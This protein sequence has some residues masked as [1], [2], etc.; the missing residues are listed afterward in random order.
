MKI[1]ELRAENFKK[2]RVVEIRPDGNLVP[3]TGKNGQ[4]KTSVL[5]AIWF[6]L[7]GK[8]ALPLK[9]VRKGTERMKV[10]L[11]TEE[12]TVT[13]TLTRE[14]SL[15]TIALEMKTGHKRDKTPQEFLDEV[16]GELTFDPLEFLQ[17]DAKAQVDMLRKTAKVDVDFDAVDAANQA[18]YNERTAI[19]REISALDGQ[20]KGIT[21][22]DGLPKQKIDEAAIMAKLN[23]AG[24]VNKKALEISQLKND[25]GTIASRVGLEKSNVQ[26]R[27]EEI[28]QQI[29]T[30]Q[31]ERAAKVEDKAE[32]DEKY[33]AAEKA[34]RDAPT[35]EPLDTAALTQELTNAQRTNRAINERTKWEELRTAREKKQKEADK[36]TRQMEARNEKKSAAIATAKIP[37]A[38][39]TFDE[40]QV[41]FNGMPL[42]SLGEGEQIRI[43]TQIGMAAN[44]KLRVLCIRHGEALD[45]DSLKILADL[46]QE[47][48][49]QVWMARVDSSGKVGIVLEDGMI[50]AHEEA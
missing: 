1:I 34:Y 14:G 27:I 22:L 46:A 30:L 29:R 8:R 45:E 32:L 3:I 16:I 5:D 6:A 24:A 48:D 44:P 43:S 49:F 20:I 36:L 9:P 37:V 33:A 7:K 19:N 2:L 41:L 11:E 50:A 40:S 12:F 35:G 47:H 31:V 26:N 28:D 18:D 10:S 25:L 4:G 23:D 13:R 17:M 38:G 15:P 42:G 21:V 39:I